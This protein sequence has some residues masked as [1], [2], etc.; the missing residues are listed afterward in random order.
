MKVQKKYAVFIKLLIATNHNI[1]HLTL[2][3][4]LKKDALFL[5]TITRMCITAFQID[6]RK[7]VIFL[8][9]LEMLE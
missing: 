6:L 8:W 5:V 3:T 2:Q 9:T 7:D 4:N 1:L